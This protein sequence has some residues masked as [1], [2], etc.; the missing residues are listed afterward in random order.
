MMAAV[1]KSPGGTASAEIL[2]GCV[3][4]SRADFAALLADDP[5]AG[6]DTL[7]DRTGAG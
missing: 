6:F 4:M 5:V 2:C 1:S 7:L 3:D